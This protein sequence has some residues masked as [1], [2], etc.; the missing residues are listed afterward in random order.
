MVMGELA[1]IVE[2]DLPVIV[3]VMND[4]AL[5]LIRFAQTR[6]NL[7]IFGTE[8]ANPN[9]EAIASGV[10]FVVCQDSKQKRM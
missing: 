1:L 4:S 10:W 6:K 9:Y 2:M 8:F 7:Q 5:D 3:V